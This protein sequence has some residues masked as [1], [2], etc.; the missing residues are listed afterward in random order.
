M[1]VIAIVL[2]ALGVLFVL[3]FAGGLV[4]ARRRANR[5]DFTEHVR[6]A[7]QALEHAR[8]TDKGWDRAKL[9]EAALA[10]LQAERPGSEWDAVHLV[11]VDDKPG[12]ADDVA[13]MVVTG[14]GGQARVELARREGGDWYVERVE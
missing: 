3:F 8:A 10:A 5:P 2:I 11:L 9:E 6:A 4:A 13:Q 7:D 12:V 1:S 14:A